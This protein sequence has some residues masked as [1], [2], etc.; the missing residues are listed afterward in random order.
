MNEHVK[1]QPLGKIDSF[2]GT[3]IVY[4][5]SMVHYVRDLTYGGTQRFYGVIGGHYNGNFFAIDH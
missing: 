1:P 2:I 5:N 3:V 4:Q